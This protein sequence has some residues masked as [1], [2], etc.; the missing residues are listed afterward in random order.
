MT[1]TLLAAPS[2]SAQQRHAEPAD[3]D[4]VARVAQA[5]EA[6]GF[7]VRVARDADEA[8]RLVLDL[9]PEGAEVNQGASVTLDSIGV[10]QEIAGS[11]RYD[12]L[13]PRLWAMDRGT[14]GREIRK[15]GAAPDVMLG[16]VHAVTQ[17]GWLVTASGSGSQLGP[18]ASGAGKV[19]LVVGSQKIVT[20]IDEAF[21][22]IETHAFPLEDQRAMDAYGMHSAINKVLVTR[23]DAPGRTTVIIVEQAIGF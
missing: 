12:A 23:A 21:D 16:S 19:V 7:T 14:Q 5:L 8:R 15:L 4:R 13:R 6:N 17:N 1:A 9:V 10:T 2:T 18:Y 3:A 20:D 11:G 22:R